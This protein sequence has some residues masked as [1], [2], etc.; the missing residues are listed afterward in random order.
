MNIYLDNT[1]LIY[2]WNKF[3]E[4]EMIILLIQ[5]FLTASFT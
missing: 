4:N 2:L 3:E 1:N 5:D